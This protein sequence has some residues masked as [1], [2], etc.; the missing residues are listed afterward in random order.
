MPFSF[1]IAWISIWIAISVSGKFCLTVH[2][3][4]IGKCTHLS[5]RQVCCSHPDKRIMM[6]IQKVSHI[7]DLL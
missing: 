5:V 4:L 6:L 2:S 7:I 1:L 3:L